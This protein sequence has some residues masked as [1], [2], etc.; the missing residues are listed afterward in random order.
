M[1]DDADA[2][3]HRLLGGEAR[4]GL[5]QRLRRHFERLPAEAPLGSIRMSD[6]P[7]AEHEALALL[8]GRP[9]RYRKSMR[10]DL[11][12]LDAALRRAGLAESLRAALERFDGPIADKAALE[13]DA[14]RRWSAV[15]A[16]IRHD[17][18]AACLA[19]GAGL[20]LLKR[21]AR[22]DAAAAMQICDAAQAVLRRLPATGQPR[23]RLA[24]ETLGD[25]HA[26][27]AGRP[28][29][30]L[31]LAVLRRRDDGAGAEQ[32]DEP[33]RV[34]MPDEPDGAERVRSV[35]ARA[36]ILVN[37]LARPALFLNLPVSAGAPPAERGEP[38][39]ASLRWLLRSLP[40]WDVAGRIVHVCENP[41]LLAIAADRLGRNCAPLVCTDG[42]PAAAQ[43]TLLAQLAAAGALLAY[44]GDFDWPG[45]RIAGRVMAEFRARA[46][47]FAAEDYEQAV[48]VLADYA[49]RLT[50]MAVVADWDE[51]LA[52]SMQRIGLAVP[53]EALAD[54]LLSDLG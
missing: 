53:E 4:A 40:R 7:A 37:E 6:I 23:A 41:N 1:S 48:T 21:L 34:G 49:Q 13:R 16:G 44:H 35:W 28:I 22:G 24:A 52:P 26:L 15:A 8:T 12:A 42:M 33:P 45:L 38:G 36:G 2:R 9:V 31:V 27:D 50:G 10:V 25:A 39:F 18:L 47:R 32:A 51:R 19:T 46:W 3:L 14:Q 17:G 54:H 30:T 20:G 43:R 29:A 11:A 5:R